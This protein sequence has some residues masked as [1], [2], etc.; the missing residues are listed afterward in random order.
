MT[1][2]KSIDAK[3]LEHLYRTNGARLLDNVSEDYHRR[4]RDKLLEQDYHGLKLSF[5]AILSH[6]NFSGT[7]LVDIAELNGMTKQAVGQMANEIEALGYIARIPDPHDGRAK[8][9]IFTDLG[10]RLIQDSI[11]AVDEVEQEY[12]QLIGTENMLQ[13]EGLLKDLSAQLEQQKL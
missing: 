11:A 6:I 12:S 4:L 7:R 5:S 13:L 3:Q 10:K 2:S 1:G 9:L 8:N